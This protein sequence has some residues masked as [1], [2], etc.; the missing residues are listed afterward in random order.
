MASHREDIDPRQEKRPARRY[1]RLTA[2]GAVKAGEALTKARRPSR[3]ALRG[4]AEVRG[5]RRPRA[6]RRGPQCS[7]QRSIDALTRSRRQCECAW[8]C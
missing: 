6:P 8:T 5:P 7:H 3:T 4:L 1:Y 2:T